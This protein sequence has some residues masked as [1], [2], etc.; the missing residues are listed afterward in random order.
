MYRVYDALCVLLIPSTYRMAVLI[1][2]ISVSMFIAS[3]ANC[4]VGLRY[5][6][7]SKM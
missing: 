7:V 1:L 5:S 6:K 4:C 2:L 3:L